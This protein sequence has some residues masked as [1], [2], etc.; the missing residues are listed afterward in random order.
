MRKE[1]VTEKESKSQFNRGPLLMDLQGFECTLLTTAEKRI[2]SPV[3]LIG[4][5][6]FLQ[7]TW[8]LIGQNIGVEFPTY[9]FFDTDRQFGSLTGM[10]V[11]ALLV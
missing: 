7:L 9:P 10:F 2:D 8:A 5:F 1:N 6:G 3:I 11:K 4:T